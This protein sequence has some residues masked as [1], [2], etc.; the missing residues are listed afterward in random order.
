MA[1]NF[2]NDGYF[3]GKVGIGI[4]VPGTI[5]DIGGM[6]DPI[7]RIKSDAGGDPQLRFDA[8]QANRGASI[9]FYDNG[10]AI[11]GFIRY[12]HN[13]DKM[14]FGA[15]TGSTANATMIVADQKSWYWKDTYF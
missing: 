6:A 5:L 12:S 8:S 4:K 1:L 10:S 7:I 14:N 3:A 13:G 11:G 15:G 2:L 9:D